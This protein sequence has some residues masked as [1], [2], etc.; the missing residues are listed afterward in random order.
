MPSVADSFVLCQTFQAAPSPEVRT[1]TESH[2][3]FECRNR[4]R[5]DMYPY[6]YVRIRMDT[7]TFGFYRICIRT[8]SQAPLR[9]QVRMDTDIRTVFACRKRV[10][11]DMYPYP[12]VRNIPAFFEEPEAG[13]LRCYVPIPR[14]C[15]ARMVWSGPDSVAQRLRS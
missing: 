7:D 6:P 9:Y 4:V 5:T 1:D 15:K 13:G 12:Y 2:T 8:S 11:T 10:R 14:V 3:V